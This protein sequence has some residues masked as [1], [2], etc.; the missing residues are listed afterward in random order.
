MSEI[1]NDVTRNALLTLHEA[2]A[3]LVESLAGYRAMLQAQEFSAVVIDQALV[4]YHH[5]LLKIAFSGVK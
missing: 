3:P 1:D 5:Y 4:E 2:V